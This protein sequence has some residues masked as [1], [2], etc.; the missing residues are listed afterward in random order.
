M[1][2]TPILILASVLLMACKP[3]SASQPAEDAG[4]NLYGAGPCAAPG[5]GA[6]PL[7][8]GCCQC[9]PNC[10][11]DV[12]AGYCEKKR[13]GF[14]LQSFRLLRPRCAFLPAANCS[15]CADATQPPATSDDSEPQ[16]VPPPKTESQPKPAPPLPPPPDS[17]KPQTGT[18]ESDSPSDITGAPFPMFNPSA[19]KIGTPAK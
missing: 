15:E 1:R 12:W 2:T 11:D 9:Q 7:Q 14:T 19:W 18:P 16:A 6:L 3:L 10:C 4:V 5:Y 8:P 13:Q 17:P